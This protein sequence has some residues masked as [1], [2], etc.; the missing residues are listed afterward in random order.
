MNISLASFNYLEPYDSI[1]IIAG[2]IELIFHRLLVGNV[3]K[4]KEFISQKYNYPIVF[5][6]LYHQ[7]NMFCTS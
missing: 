6:T 2:F 1:N 4:F 5:L 3:N 7:N